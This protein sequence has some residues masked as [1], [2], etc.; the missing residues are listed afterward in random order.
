VTVLDEPSGKL[1]GKA[2]SGASTNVIAYS[3]NLNHLYVLQPEDGRLAI[4]G[5]SKTG[6]GELLKIVNTGE[7]SDC[8]IAD[9]R[10]RSTYAILRAA[11]SLRTKIR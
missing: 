5:I 6:V 4:V 1:L 9:D 7:R 8:M 2:A 10:E 3:Q 11:N